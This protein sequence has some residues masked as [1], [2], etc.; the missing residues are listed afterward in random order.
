MKNYAKARYLT[1]EEDL[2][3][4]FEIEIPFDH[5]DPDSTKVGLILRLGFDPTQAIKP[6]D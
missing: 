1:L 2:G 6:A 3:I 4:F 5:A